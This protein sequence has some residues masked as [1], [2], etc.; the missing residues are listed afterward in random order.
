MPFLVYLS[1]S[2][3]RLFFANQFHDIFQ[4][5]LVYYIFLILY[6]AVSNHNLLHHLLRIKEYCHV[7]LVNV[8]D[9]SDLWDC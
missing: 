4:N 3:C 6:L 9:Q 5:H 7:L 8:F 2:H 1:L